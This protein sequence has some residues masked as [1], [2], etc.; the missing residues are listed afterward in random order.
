MKEHIERRINRRTVL[1]GASVAGGAAILGTTPAAANGNKGGNGKGGACGCPDGMWQVAKFE[2]VEGELIF[3]KTGIPKLDPSDDFT[4]SNIHLKNGEDDPEEIAKVDWNSYPYA[5]NHVTV[6]TGDGCF[7]IELED[8]LPGPDGVQTGSE[9]GAIDIADL[10]TNKAISHI[11]FC[12]QPF[13]QIDLANTSSPYDIGNVDSGGFVHGAVGTGFGCIG[14]EAGPYGKGW[15]G[16]YNGF[17]IKGDCERVKVAFEVLS[18]PPNADGNISLIT[19]VAPAFLPKRSG[20]EDRWWD[21]ADEQVIYQEDNKQYDADSLG[22][23][24][25]YAEIPTS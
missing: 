16:G 22:W 12:A 21:I 18:E 6:K 19:A 9:E 5:I 2:N 1:K 3:E 11:V 4:F 7:N 13:W 14:R 17:Q 20:N 10:D 24:D 25:L 15:L 23:D 8:E